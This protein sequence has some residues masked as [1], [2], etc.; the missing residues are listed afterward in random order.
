M[1]PMQITRFTTIALSSVILLTACRTTSHNYQ[2]AERTGDRMV[3]YRNDAV[4]IQDSI[5]ATVAALDELVEQAHIDPRRPFRDFSRAVDEVEKANET[6]LRRADAM[7][8][9]GKVFFDQWQQEI[10]TIS[11]P[12]ARELAEERRTTLDRT[13]RNISH[14]SVEVRDE[15]RPWL[16]NVR[17]LQTLLSNDLTVAGIDSARSLIST[18]KTDGAKLT[19]TYDTLID[20]LNSVLSAMTP[21]PTTAQ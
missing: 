7:R 11:N 20:E 10:S 5:A 14:V 9:E 21:A 6:A 4:A 17:D 13:F 3:A 1:N 8:A 16:D 15:L 2:Q 18:T 19:L 12:E